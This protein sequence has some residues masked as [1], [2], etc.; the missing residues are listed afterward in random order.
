MAVKK[1]YGEEEI[2]HIYLMAPKIKK[3]EQEQG[4][5]PKIKLLFWFC[6][7]KQEI[8]HL[9]KRLS[10]ILRQFLAE[11]RMRHGNHCLRT[12]A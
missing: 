7:T 9:F 12:L 10:R 6:C 11:C 5:I 2:L 1:V 8:K 4:K 3:P